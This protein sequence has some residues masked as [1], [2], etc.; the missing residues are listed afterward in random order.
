MHEL[1]RDIRVGQ[2]AF[3]ALLGDS[4][5]GFTRYAFEEHMRMK[6]G[7]EI[8]SP[9]NEC[10]VYPYEP[11]NGRKRY[12]V[13]HPGFEDFSLYVKDRTDA[14]VARGPRRCLRCLGSKPTEKKIV[15]MMAIPVSSAGQFQYVGWVTYVEVTGCGPLDL[16]AYMLPRESGGSVETG[17]NQAISNAFG[18]PT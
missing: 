5:E 7:M 18:R 14:S 13:D 3:K 17:V 15:R 12:L 4:I 16:P 10:M 8:V 9:P 11:T 1:I 2:L 6:K